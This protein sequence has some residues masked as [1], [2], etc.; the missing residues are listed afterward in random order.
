MQDY[1]VSFSLPL[2]QQTH[3]HKSLSC[4]CV[5]VCVCVCFEDLIIIVFITAP[6][7]LIWSCALVNFAIVCVELHC[8][9]SHDAQTKIPRTKS[10]WCI[11]WTI[12]WLQN[13]VGIWLECISSCGDSS[14]W[15][16]LVATIIILTSSWWVLMFP[17]DGRNDLLL[18]HNKFHMCSRL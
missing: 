2:S 7:P 10:K 12:L 9:L 18:C 17:N 11:F 16:P 15:P 14:L 1:H 6:P 5:C 13:V 8:F 4:V 3:M